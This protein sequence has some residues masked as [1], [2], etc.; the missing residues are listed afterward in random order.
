[1]YLTF[2]ARA[3]TLLCAALKSRDADYVACNYLLGNPKLSEDKL[4]AFTRHTETDGLAAG[5]TADD[6]M[7]MLHVSICQSDI[8]HASYAT[9]ELY[10]RFRK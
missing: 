1:M 8:P 3:I 7:V 9:L 4:F 2:T 6:M 5:Y 10:P